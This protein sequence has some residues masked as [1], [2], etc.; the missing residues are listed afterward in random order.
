MPY[1]VHKGRKMRGHLI[2]HL[3]LI[4]GHF[5]QVGL[6]SIVFSNY[7]KESKSSFKQGGAGRNVAAVNV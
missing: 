6:S 2:S 1:Y 7:A 3:F 4:L 5:F